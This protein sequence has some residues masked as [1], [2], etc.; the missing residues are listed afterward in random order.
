LDGVLSD[1]DEFTRWGDEFSAGTHT[2]RVTVEDS[3]GNTASDEIEVVFPANVGPTVEILTPEEGATFYQSQTISF[4]ARSVDV[5][6]PPS[7]TLDE[8][9]VSWFIGDALTPFATGHTASISGYAPGTYTVTLV[10]T[11]GFLEARDTVTFSIV[12]DP[13]DLSP[14]AEII[15][16]DHLDEFNANAEDS[17]GWYISVN[18]IGQGNDPEDGTLAGGS[19]VW[20]DR[21]N[22]GP[23]QVIGTGTTFTAKLYAPQCFGNTHQITLTVTDSSGKTH[24]VSI[25]VTVH[26]LC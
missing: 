9:Q 4:T 5:D 2:I 7:Y 10:G 23:P 18:F 26:L 11:D 12:A 22:G 13:V 14:T 16:P 3:E 24:S 21:V 19:L 17:G 25:T 1:E 6:H 15:D 8:D 20:T